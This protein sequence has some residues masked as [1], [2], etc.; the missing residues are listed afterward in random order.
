[1]SGQGIG[2]RLPGMRLVLPAALG[3]FILVGVLGLVLP[4]RERIRLARGLE[5][6]GRQLAVQK[7]LYPLYVELRDADHVKDWP[8]LA[9][10]E[11]KPLDEEAVLA[12]QELF[13]K[14][15]KGH[16]MEL[17]QVLVQA[18]T[19][20][21]A[22]AL[23]VV[24]PLSGLYGKLGPFLADAIRLP[25]FDSVVRVLVER[26]DALDAMTVELKLALE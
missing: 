14:M 5:Q 23:Q 9:V 6:A 22:R 8:S 17:G 1:M 12:V 15:A 24:L 26:S 21:G 19:E 20:E 11:L 25:A 3:A 16:G 13:G 10:P 4:I 7:T 18:Q 2:M